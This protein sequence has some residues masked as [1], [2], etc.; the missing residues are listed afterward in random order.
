MVRFPDKIHP[1]H[2]LRLRFDYQLRAYQYLDYFNITTW[3]P[4]F[5]FF[6]LD[7]TFAD[8]SELAQFLSNRGIVRNEVDVS[9]AFSQ[10]SNEVVVV[11]TKKIWDAEESIIK[12]LLN[13]RYYSVNEVAEMLSFSRPTVYKL[14]NDQAV[15]AIR[16]FG[17]L[18]INHMELM[19]F[20]N[21]ESQQ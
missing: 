17:Q 4:T 1:K 15:K 2:G 8:G 6:P 10:L 14:V 7:L 12:Y 3:Y 20:I 19:A 21:K 9:A 11:D 18:R 5:K 13:Y 16:I